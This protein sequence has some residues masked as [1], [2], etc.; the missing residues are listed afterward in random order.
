MKS[1][2]LLG[3]RTPSL[4]SKR[5]VA[6]IVVVGLIL[7]TYLQMTKFSSLADVRRTV[8]FMGS[9]GLDESTAGQTLS[10]RYK[11]SWQTKETCSYRADL[12]GNVL[13][14]TENATGG[15]R[16]IYGLVSDTYHVRMITDP[17]IDCAWKVSFIPS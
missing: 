16:S 6:I 13:F 11:V 9:G 7:F 1:I 10:G 12:D 14:S 5:L 3:N 8:I 4:A 15:T 17:A 2:D